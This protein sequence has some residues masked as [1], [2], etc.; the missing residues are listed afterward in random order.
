MYISRRLAQNNCVTVRSDWHFSSAAILGFAL[1]LAFPATAQSRGATK[2]PPNA[3]QRSAPAEDA[4]HQ[5][6][7]RNEALTAAVASGSPQAVAESSRRVAA[8]AMNQVAGLRMLVGAYPQALELY[9]KA[10]VL[11][12][13]PDIRIGIAGAA[14]ASGDA[15][16]AIAQTTTLL[17]TDPK[18]PRIWLINGKAWGIKKDYSKSVQSLSR[19]LELRKDIDVQ[20]ALALAYL[21]ANQKPKAEAVFQ[22]IIAENGD[23]AIWHMV[24]GGA[25]RQ[26]KDTDSAVREFKRALA[27]DPNVHRGHFYLALTIL[28][29]NHWA[30]TDE[31]MAELRESLKQEPKN[32]FANLFVGVGESQQQQFDLSDKHLQTAAEVQPDSPEIWLYLGMNAFQQSKFEDAKKYFLRAVELTGGNEAQNNY[33]I[34]RAYISLGRIE[35]MGGNKELAEKYAQKAKA[36]QAKAMANM[37]ESL[38]EMSSGMGPAPGIIPHEKLPEQNT[39]AEA[40]PVDPTAAMDPLALAS[41]SLTPERQAQVKELETNLRQILSNCYNDWGTADARQK[42]YPLAL[43]HFQE[44]ERWNS[45]TPGVLRNVGLAAMKVGDQQEAIRGFRAAVTA[46]PNDQ[47]AR[48][49]LAMLLF[50]ASDYAEAAKQ[51]DSLGDVAFTDPAV[52]YAWA[53]SLAQNNQ[54]KNAGA[55]LNRLITAQLPAELLLSIGD[56]YSVLQDYDHAVATYQRVLQLN[57]AMPLA[58]YKMGA[59][60]IRLSRPAEAIPALESELKI[61]PENVDV[62]FNLSYALLQVSQKDRALVILRSIVAAHPEHPQAQYQLGKTLLDDGQ[63]EQALKHLEA[64]ARLDPDRDYIHYQLQAAYRKVGRK[65]DADREANLYK[66]IKARKREQATIPMPQKS[67]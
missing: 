10:Q 1:L 18:N 63:I 6:Q 31:S 45:A 55:V 22:Q 50:Q 59:A 47:L 16:E 2:A 34:R 4:M 48:A 62:Q 23:R 54:Q 58:H 32:F 56:L 8:L 29:D 5:L 36:M 19:S 44:A 9:R 57:P 17:E 21:Q 11:E 25:Y 33:D 66:E 28:E 41:T 27:M 13:T 53:Y 40:A 37:A 7:R 15:D 12:D 49:R 38:S 20:Y 67:E 42:L 65:E 35:F 51:F 46:D 60:L 26:I 39:L 24:F 52:A 3:S 43:Q 30:R 64:A 61:A 14:L